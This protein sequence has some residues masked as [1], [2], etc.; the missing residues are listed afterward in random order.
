MSLQPDSRKISKY[1]SKSKTVSFSCLKKHRLRLKQD[2]TQERCYFCDM[3]EH[4]IRTKYI[5]TKMMKDR[6]DL[7]KPFFKE[8]K[9]NEVGL[10]DQAYM[11]N[12][13]LGSERELF[14]IDVPMLTHEKLNKEEVSCEEKQSIWFDPH[15]DPVNNKITNELEAAISD[16]RGKLLSLYR[17][18]N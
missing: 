18:F 4:T 3:N 7:K 11:D 14:D 12:F 5:K 8:S 6:G 15:V 9:T 10:I 2:Q 13:L 17:Q 1:Q 16:L